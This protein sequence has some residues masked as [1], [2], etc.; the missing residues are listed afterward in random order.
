MEQIPTA[1]IP[2]EQT[3]TVIIPIRKIKK[4]KKIQ[5]IKRIKRIRKRID[6]RV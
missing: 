3:L 6:T 2:M 5:K 4:I 1:Q